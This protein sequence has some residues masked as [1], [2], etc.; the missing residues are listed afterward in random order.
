[1]PHYLDRFVNCKITINKTVQDP[2]GGAYG[3]D[4]TGP[5]PI[6]QDLSCFLSKK[7][8]TASYIAGKY[9]GDDVYQILVK[10]S[11]LTFE[12]SSTPEELAK[13]IDAATD[14]IKVTEYNG[15]TNHNFIGE[16]RI[17]GFDP[18]RGRNARRD[19]HAKLFLTR[20]KDIDDID[21]E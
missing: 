11:L 6:Y 16:Y 15:S 14:T 18:E 8:Q 9:I 7:N 17:V 3:S 4:E 20:V 2:D 12:D 1:M 21:E 10:R 13:R 19:L 5:T